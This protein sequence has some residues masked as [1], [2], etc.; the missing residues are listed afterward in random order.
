MVPIKDGV[1]YILA[2]NFD[3]SCLFPIPDHIFR[4]IIFDFFSLPV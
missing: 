1:E 3:V 4:V 2:S